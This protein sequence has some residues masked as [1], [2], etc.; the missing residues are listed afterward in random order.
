MTS[1]FFGIEFRVGCNNTIATNH[2]IID[3]IGLQ[4]KVIWAKVHYPYLVYYKDN[5]AG[6]RGEWCK[7]TNNRPPLSLL[8]R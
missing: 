5:F 1:H 2:E 6:Y 8:L 3:G 7:E 4:L